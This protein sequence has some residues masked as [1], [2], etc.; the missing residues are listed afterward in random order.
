MAICLRARPNG[1]AP[2]P[3]PRV[4]FVPREGEPAVGA[5]DRVLARSPRS[6]TRIISITARLI[7]RI[8]TAPHKVVGIFRKETQGGRILPIDKGADRQWRVR[9]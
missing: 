9:S 2:R 6:R 4:L 8:G 1:T 5:G 7:R 3:E